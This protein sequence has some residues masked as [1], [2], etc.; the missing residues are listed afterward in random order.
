[1]PDRNERAT[2]LRGLLNKAAHAYYVLDKPVLEDA[3]YDRLY[4]ELVDLEQA[5]PSL[6]STDSLC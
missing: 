5:D 1:M 6:I 2:E 4:R 3:I